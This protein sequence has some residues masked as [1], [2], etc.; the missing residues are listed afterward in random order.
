MAR[1]RNYPVR[2]PYGECLLFSSAIA[3]ICYFYVDCPSA[4]KDNYMKVL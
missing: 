3:I 4:I 1:R 2:I